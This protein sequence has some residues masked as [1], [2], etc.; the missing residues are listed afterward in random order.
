M[1][2]R[3][4]CIRQPIIWIL[5]PAILLVSVT[6]EAHT[7]RVLEEQIKLSI[8]RVDVQQNSIII[9]YDITLPTVDDYE[10]QVVM[11]SEKNASVKIPVITA[12]GDIGEKQYTSGEKQITWNYRKDIGEATYGDGFYFEISIRRVSGSSWWIYALLGA[13]VIGGGAAALGGK[14]SD[15]STSTPSQVTEL[16]SPPGRPGN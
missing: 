15:G 9:R 14:K 12:S 8:Q 2:M 10:V 7:L 5:M 1:I 16:P 6:V 3:I 11:R 13:A 4:S